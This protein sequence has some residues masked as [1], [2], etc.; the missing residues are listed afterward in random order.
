MLLTMMFCSYF[1]VALC[2]C[3]AT[4]MNLMYSC[5]NR[6]VFIEVALNFRD[7]NYL[8]ILFPSLLK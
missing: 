1:T 4:A 7:F 6:I 8:L 2:P 5:I 3:D